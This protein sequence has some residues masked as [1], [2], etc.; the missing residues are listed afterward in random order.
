M[1]FWLSRR[2]FIRAL[3]IPLSLVAWGYPVSSGFAQELQV[4]RWNH[5]PI[6]RNFLTGSYTNTQGEITFDPVLLIEDAEF[7]I[8]TWLL[9]YV[10]AFELFDR[11]ARMEVRQA[12]QDGTWSGLVNGAPTTVSR[13]GWSDTFLRFAVNLIGAPPLEGEEYA[14]YRATVDEETIVGLALGVQIPT[15]QYFEDKLINL[16]SNRF[17]FRPQIGFQHRK[18]NWTVEATGTAWLYTDNNS[19][20]GGN[21]LEQDPFYTVDGSIEYRFD[22]GLWTSASAGIGVGGKSTVNGIEKDDYKKNYAW[23]V[24]M[25]IPLNRSTSLK[26]T[27]VE[28]DHWSEIGSRS[29]SINIGLLTSW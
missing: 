11:T 14:R 2:Y 25:G 9:A 29:Q 8:D 3:L 15:G 17:T 27:Y 19:F 10:R 4:R 13:T 16:G 5:L 23:A 28:T 21:T 20:F 6:N 1:A 12:W 7:E 24:G 26:A 22:S 18:D